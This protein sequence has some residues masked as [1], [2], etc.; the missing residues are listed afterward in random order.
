MQNCMW[1]LHV[2]W[3]RVGKA[4]GVGV[5]LCVQGRWGTQEASF[6]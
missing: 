6:L 4:W 2:G 5:C 3:V 1:R